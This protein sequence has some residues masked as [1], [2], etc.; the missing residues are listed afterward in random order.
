M[1]KKQLLRLK[2]GVSESFLAGLQLERDLLVNY[3]TSTEGR[4]L[5]RACVEAAKEWLDIT[6]ICDV[7]H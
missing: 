2:R 1:L 3:W 7:Y 6:S 5:V 4:E